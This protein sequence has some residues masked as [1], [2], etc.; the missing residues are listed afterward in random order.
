MNKEKKVIVKKINEVL[1]SLWSDQECNEGKVI[2]V[3]ESWKH[4][5]QDLMSR[6]RQVGWHVCR[7]VEINSSAPGMHKHY[8]YFVNPALRKPGRARFEA[9]Y[10]K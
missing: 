10:G 9:K 5:V 8:L 4:H 6:Y 2:E 1:E 3:K 7:R